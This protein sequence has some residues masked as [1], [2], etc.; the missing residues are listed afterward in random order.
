MTAFTGTQYPDIVYVYNMVFYTSEEGGVKMGLPF[1][2]ANSKQYQKHQMLKESIPNKSVFK[3]SAGIQIREDDSVETKDDSRSRAV[4]SDAKTSGLSFGIR[5]YV[6][7]LLLIFG[8][9]IG[10]HSLLVEK[11]PNMKSFVEKLETAA[12][13]IGLLLVFIGVFCFLCNLFRLAPHASS[14]PQ[15][16][17][18]VL[19]ILLLKKHSGPIPGQCLERINLPDTLDWPPWPWVSCTWSLGGYRCCKPYEPY[20]ET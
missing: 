14:L 8:G 11:V 6:F 1:R 4:S 3:A 17:G 9:M 15:V 16:A 19:G 12:M 5:M 2:C 18:V 13:P 7:S 10:A 20:F